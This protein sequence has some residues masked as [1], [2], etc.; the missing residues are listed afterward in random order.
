MVKMSYVEIFYDKEAVRAAVGELGDMLVRD[1]KISAAGGIDALADIYY[2]NRY[3]VVVVPRRV[4]RQDIPYNP[5]KQEIDQIAYSASF[6]AQSELS[7][8]GLGGSELAAK[9][10]MPVN[11]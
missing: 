9:L 1:V 6:I 10:A 11:E 2:S 4:T 5:N 3:G 7:G 8:F